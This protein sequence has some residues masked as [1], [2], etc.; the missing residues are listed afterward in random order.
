MMK[1]FESSRHILF[2][3]IFIVLPVIASILLFGEGIGL[4]LTGTDAPSRLGGW[5]IIAMTAFFLWFMVGSYFKT[6]YNIGQGELHYKAGFN[7]GVIPIDSIRAI[8]RSS[9]LTAGNRPALDLRGLV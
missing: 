8:K 9:Y 1:R 4:I 7:T 3:F 5:L 6:E 2:V